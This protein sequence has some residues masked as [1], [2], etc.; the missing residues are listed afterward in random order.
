M[1]VLMFSPRFHDLVERGLKTQTIRGDR[2]RPIEPGDPLSLRAWTGSP[3]RSPQRVLRESICLGVDPVRID[4]EAD[5]LLIEVRGIYLG[6]I[7][8][9]QF[10]VADGFRDISDM[11]RH[12]RSVRKTPFTGVVIRW[13]APD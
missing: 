1:A 6:P 13:E 5:Q 11:A 12:Y 8:T 9:Q 4:F 7:R 2:K 10:A 3:Y